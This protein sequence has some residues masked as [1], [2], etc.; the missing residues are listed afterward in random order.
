MRRRGS[1]RAVREHMAL[2]SEV[3]EEYWADKFRKTPEGAA[4]F[5]RLAGLMAARWRSDERMHV[6]AWELPDWS[7]GSIRAG[8]NVWVCGDGT[9]ELPGIGDN[10]AD[11]V[12]L[13]SRRPP[14]D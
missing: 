7:R 11:V 1:S 12:Q 5:D 9:I 3:S 10:L 6:G 14:T 2:R 4:H 13:A 8:L